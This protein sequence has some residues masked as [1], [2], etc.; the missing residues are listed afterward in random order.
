MG[1]INL[2]FLRKILNLNLSAKEIES[3]KNDYSLIRES[4]IN[5]DCLLDIKKI[6]AFNKHKKE[7]IDFVEKYQSYIQE[8]EKNDVLYEMTNGFDVYHV[9]IKIKQ[10][11]SDFYKSGMNC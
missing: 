5:Y 9:S 6:P 8:F 11:D 4:V 7:I 3:F 10:E 2:T 1:N